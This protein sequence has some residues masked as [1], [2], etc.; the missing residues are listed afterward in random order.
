[1]IILLQ[2]NKQNKSGFLESTELNEKINESSKLNS[3]SEMTKYMQ[4]NKM[5]DGLSTQ[6]K[7]FSHSVISRYPATSPKCAPGLFCAT[8]I[9]GGL[10]KKRFSRPKR[11]LKNK[12]LSA[13]SFFKWSKQIKFIVKTAKELGPRKSPRWNHISTTDMQNLTPRRSPR[14]NNI[15]KGCPSKLSLINS[16]RKS[17]K[18]VLNVISNDTFL[19]SK[20]KTYNIDLNEARRLVKKSIARNKLNQK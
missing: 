7:T 2:D 12:D 16:A 8:G 4:E 11:I 9:R 15:K 14:L 6:S 1:M 18:R 13:P 3:L 17:S 19:T 5:I 10:G 20:M